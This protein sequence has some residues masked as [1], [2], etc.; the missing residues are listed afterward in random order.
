MEKPIGN[1]VSSLDY[2]V[3]QAI[4]MVYDDSLS[5]SELL[6]KVVSTLNAMT[7]QWND[8]VDWVAGDGLTTEI[9]VILAGWLADGTIA[10]IINNVVL[11]QKADKTY[12][13]AEIIRAQTF[14]NVMGEGA[15]GDGL[16]DDAAIIQG[17]LDRGLDPGNLGI[18]VWFPAGTY[19]LKSEL[20]IKRNTK[21]LLHPN[22]VL[23][24]QH[25]DQILTNYVPLGGGDEVYGGYTG[26]GNICIEGGIWDCNANA[27]PDVGNGIGL[28][29]ADGVII[30]DLTIKDTPIGHALELTGCRNVIVQNCKFIGYG[31]AA[32]ANYWSEAIQIEAA[33]P[34]GEGYT[35]GYA[36]DYTPSKDITVRDC[37]FGPSASLPAHP[38]G[39]GNHGARYGI[40]YDNVQ[41]LNN[42]F[43]GQ[44]YFAIRPFK[45]RQCLIDGNLI[46]NGEGGIYIVT[47]NSGV[48]IEDTAGISQSPEPLENFTIVNNIL[49]NLT[50][51]PIWVNGEITSSAFIYNVI[52]KGNTIKDCTLKGINIWYVRD[53]I[54][55]GNVVHNSDDTAIQ[56]NTGQR[57][58]ISDNQLYDIGGNGMFLAGCMHTNI[59]GN[60]L[61]TIQSH[62]LNIS[63]DVV[64]LSIINN[65]ITDASQKTNGTYDGILITNGASSITIKDNILKGWSTIK[66]RYGLNIQT[67]VVGV[68]RYGND[69]RV[70]GTLGNLIDSSTTPITTSAD[71]TV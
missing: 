43:V 3:Q 9:D 67:G 1:K 61:D 2:W 54:I 28:A 20:H 7:D 46:E 29:H 19:V 56:V 59:D 8:V 70:G 32:S 16:T 6:A 12:V 68:I 21:L 39:V 63:G 35:Y 33:F 65:R 17:I 27:F 60:I 13:D 22:A 24:R 55:S 34:P 66:M 26:H 42:H 52:I 49:R 31:V 69:L 4:P 15:K 57:V 18:S 38:C 53:L 58:I 23:L 30:R 62:G 44:S 51:Y 37:Y 41:I 40:F 10:D 5:Y 47:P 50:D 11:E 25:N 14:I 36:I 45:F 71:I 48:S 64:A